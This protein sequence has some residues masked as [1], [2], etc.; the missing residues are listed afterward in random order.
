MSA[1]QDKANGAAWDDGYRVGR[2]NIGI[3]KSGRYDYA[4]LDRC[5]ERGYRQHFA[6]QDKEEAK[7]WFMD[8]WHEAQDVMAARRAGTF[9]CGRPL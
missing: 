5:F 8:G 6:S 4:Q 1:T 7:G 9:L 2:K 3:T